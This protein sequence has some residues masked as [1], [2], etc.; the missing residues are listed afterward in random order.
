MMSSS[1]QVEPTE[2]VALCI[3]VQEGV[4]PAS[5]KISQLETE[6]KQMKQISLFVASVLGFGH[7]FSFS[8]SQ[9]INFLLGL[10]YDITRC[11]S[12]VQKYKQKKVFWILCTLFRCI[13]LILY[14]SLNNVDIERR[15]S[16][17][18]V[19]AAI[20]AFYCLNFGIIT[21]SSTWNKWHKLRN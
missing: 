6:A 13:F 4:D 12:L 16:E 11:R 9:H 5:M 1:P 10:F 8:F 20:L 17:V 7:L 2:L 3:K 18:S 19:R 15:K 21:Q 14:A